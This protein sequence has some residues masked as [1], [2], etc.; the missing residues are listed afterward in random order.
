ME[1]EHRFNSAFVG[2]K[3]ESITRH[4]VE[5]A[6]DELESALQ[7]GRAMKRRETSRKNFAGGLRFRHRRYFVSWTV[8]Q[9]KNAAEFG[10]AWRSQARLSVPWRSV[11][12][13]FTVVQPQDDAIVA[14]HFRISRC[15][16]HPRRGALAGLR[17]AQEQIPARFRI[18]EPTAVNL[19]S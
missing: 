13:Q 2:Y 9:D 15:L 4:H 16:P 1:I 10:F 12:P 6:M 14:Q 18:D 3:L 17:V 5:Q 19:N 7:P 8:L 11:H